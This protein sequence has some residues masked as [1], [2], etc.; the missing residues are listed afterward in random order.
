MRARAN[1]MIRQ[2]RTGCRR[3]SFLGS[4]AASLLLAGC[5]T[6]SAD[7]GLTPA[8]TVAYAELNKDIAKVLSEADAQAIQTRVDTLLKRPL[9]PDSAVQV[10]LLKNRGLQAEF[11][12]LGVSEAEFIT[13]TLPPNPTVAL[14]R[15]GGSLELEIE[16][17]ILI[18]L[19]EL[20]T[21]PAG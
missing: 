12:D 3:L 1:P 9:T 13:A 10:A 5:Q 7:A 15:L 8:R 18:G 2:E 19:F 20:A 14:S 17:Q 16:R 11:N 4:V 6:F 21:L